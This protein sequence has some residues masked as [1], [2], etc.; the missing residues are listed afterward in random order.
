M[1]LKLFKAVWFFSLLAVLGAFLYMY[2]SLPETVILV[3]SDNVVSTSREVLFYV[4]VALL[5]I[6]NTVVFILS[7]LHGGREE[8]FLSWFFGLII[9]LNFFFIIALSYVSL[10]NSSEKFDYSRIG[11]VIYG[12]VGLMILWALGW[13]IYSVLRNFSNKQSV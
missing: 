6:I 8:D 4:V 9:T 13:P 12:S 5:A 3:E 2:A 7:K 1:V 11:W 10:Y